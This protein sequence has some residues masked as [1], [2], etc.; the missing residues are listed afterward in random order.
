MGGF[1][2]GIDSDRHLQTR[3]TIIDGM[4]FIDGMDI[5]R[6]D[7]HLIDWI[8][9]LQTGQTSYR[10]NK[11]LQTDGRNGHMR[12]DKPQKKRDTRWK[13]C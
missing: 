11:L 4:D 3:Q 10:Q 7:R 2:D 8:D 13:K 1:L 5:Y 6:L 9:I 12:Q